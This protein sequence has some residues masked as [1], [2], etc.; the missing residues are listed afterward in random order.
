MKKVVT[1]LV[2]IAFS[3]ILVGCTANLPNA[4]L[5]AADY[6]VGG[7]EIIGP[8]TGESTM[9]G[10]FQGLIILQPDAGFQSA[11]DDA[12]SKASNANALINV[13][14]DVEVTQYFFGLYI[15]V[16]THVHATAIR[17]TN[18]DLRLE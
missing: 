6:S 11:Y 18:Y 12:L 13:Y 4:N 16:T 9:T 8:V 7:Y 1:L 5:G 15:E 17:T 2:L 10:L 3:A 14:S